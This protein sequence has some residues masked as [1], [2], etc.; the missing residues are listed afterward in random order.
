MSCIGGAIALKNIVLQDI[1]PEDSG[2][3]PGFD[4]RLVL[5]LEQS[6]RAPAFT[7]RSRPLGS[8]HKAQHPCPSDD[9]S[10]KT[11]P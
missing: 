2:D 4:L 6:G 9:G 10:R 7:D 3:S 8:A 1:V 11:S 5:A